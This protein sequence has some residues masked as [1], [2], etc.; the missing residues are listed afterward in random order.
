MLLQ[1][2]LLLDLDN[3]YYDRV[4]SVT[5]LGSVILFEWIEKIDFFFVSVIQGFL[6][7]LLFTCAM[8]LLRYMKVKIILA[9]KRYFR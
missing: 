2:V 9:I 8:T 1:I 3:I 5:V 6:L 4:L 7:L